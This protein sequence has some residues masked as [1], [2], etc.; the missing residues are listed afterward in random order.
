MPGLATGDGAQIVG[1]ELVETGAAQP[2][3]FGGHRCG[4]LFPAK[5]GQHLAD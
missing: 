3:F 4:N 5:G 2:E 1:V